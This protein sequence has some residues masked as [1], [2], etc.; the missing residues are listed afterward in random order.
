M[1]KCEKC[2]VDIPNAE[3]RD[4]PVLHISGVYCDICYN[5]LNGLNWVMGASLYGSVWHSLS[6]QEKSDFIHHYQAKQKKELDHA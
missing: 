1:P 5:L 3:W 2:G 6:L 4:F